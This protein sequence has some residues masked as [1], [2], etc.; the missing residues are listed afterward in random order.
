M[1]IE[2]DLRNSAFPEHKDGEQMTI[3]TKHILNTLLANSVKRTLS[4]EFS[5]QN[6]QFIAEELG[7][8]RALLDFSSFFG[9][10]ENT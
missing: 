10:Q 6:Q 2:L 9:S 3:Y 7:Y 4:L 8:R 1:K 5:E